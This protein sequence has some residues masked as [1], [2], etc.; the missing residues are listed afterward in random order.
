MSLSLHLSARSDELLA[1]LRPALAAARARPDSRRRGSP[2]PVPVLVPSAQLGEWLQVRLARDFGLSM[3]FEF[4]SPHAFFARTLTSGPDAEMFAA[5]HASWSPEALCWRVLPLVDTYAGH[6]GHEE[7]KALSPRDRFAFARLLS[8][9]LDRYARHRPD[10]PLRWR[11]GASGLPSAKPD[12]DA[13]SD[14][15]WQRELWRAVANSPDTPPHPAEVIARAAAD[16]ASSEDTREPVFVVGADLLDP[17]VL[18]T[19]QRLSAAGHAVSIYVLLPSLGFLGDQTR[20]AYLNALSAAEVSLDE[21]LELGG[22]PLL[23]SLGQQAVGHFLLL[24][25]LSPDFSEWPE[26]VD[27]PL[28]SPRNASLLAR[29]QSDIREQRTPPGP[30]RVEG[31]PDQRERLSKDDASVRVHACHSPRRELEVLRD[32]L[33]RAF[34]DIPDLRPDEVLVAVSDFDTYAPLAEAILRGGPRPLPVRL[35]AVSARE[36]NPVAVGLLA[37]LRLSLGRRT[38]SELV[39]LLNLSAVQHHLDLAGSPEVLAHLADTVRD[40]GLTHDIDVTDR[41][42][43][44]DTGTWRGAL[45]RHL[46]GTWFGQATG[47]RD[48]AGE[49]VHPLAPELHH[50]DEERLRFLNWITCLAR[51]ELSWRVAAPAHVW[52][53]R[54]SLAVDSLLSAP[55]L[56]DH[57]A[58]VHRLLD[59]LARVGNEVPLDAGALVDWLEGNLEN[60]TSL[61]TSMGGEIV[62]GRLSQLHGLPC[63]VFALL[64]L[65]DGAFPRAS[66]RP[67][68]DLLAH[69]PERWDA[70]PRRQDRQWFLDALLAPSERLILTAANRSLRTPHDGPLSSCVEELLRAAAATVRPPTDD[71]PVERHLVVRHPIQ[72]FSADY[73]EEGAMVPRSFDPISARIAT[74][75]NGVSSA[76]PRPF[77][78]SA[79]QADPVEASTTPVKVMLEELIS[80]WRNPARGWLRA[81]EIEVVEEAED[82]SEMDHAPIGLNALQSYHVHRHAL[83][84]LLPES[85][86]DSAEARSLLIA[87]RALPPGALGA[88]AWQLHEKNIASLAAELAAVLP[89]TR[90]RAVAAKLPNGAVLTG[91]INLAPSAEGAVG[92][93]WVRVYRPGKYEKRPGYQI[94]AFIQTLAAAVHLDRPVA[95]RVFGTD[96]EVLKV[97]PAISPAEA[98]RHLT[99][100]LEGFRRGRHVPL[101]FAPGASS[102]MVPFLERDDERGALEKASAV[103]ASEGFGDTPAGEGA[104]ASAQLVWRDTDPFAPPHDVEWL[105]WARLVARPLRDWWDNKISAGPGATD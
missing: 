89:H 8:Q 15:R 77:F 18:R 1:K 34:R 57:A 49:F 63:R 43:P 75:L 41:E 67:A 42:R 81:L 59:E 39:E 56:D 27:R 3:G 14:E 70:D 95:C 30:P 2:R 102:E 20:R 5:A 91:E 87:D 86:L 62:V 74:D 105:A 29:L 94:G 58:A 88:L 104:E 73:F 44:D 51:C 80:F 24:E 85:A 92:E 22:H 90:T 100:L 40:S 37:L 66:R 36:A 17:L 9:Q 23:S 10:W 50:N 53:E 83:A 32:E 99:E 31:A 76:A 61:R 69:A 98:R 78:N 21:A 19:L 65:Q 64:G 45:D 16:D 79:P 48:A 28:S 93:P 55:E 4:V 26:F 47:V 6:L 68:W 97:L 96:D 13:A 38:A 84:C 46:A 60:A 103:W 101:C 82:D 71:N 11:A 52:A 25:N 35:T 7:G 72:P 33:L 12:A 54:L